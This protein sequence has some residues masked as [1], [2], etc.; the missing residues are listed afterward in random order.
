MTPSVTLTDGVA[1]PDAEGGIVGSV[2]QGSPESGEQG[3][4]KQKKPLF[5]ATK[6]GFPL[7]RN[8]MPGNRL[9]VR[10]PCPPFSFSREKSGFSPEKNEVFKAPGS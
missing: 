10:I 3:V 5:S 4:S 6:Q 2:L 9:R 1:L 7:S 8:Q